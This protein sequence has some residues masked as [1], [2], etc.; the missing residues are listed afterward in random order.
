MGEKL[1]STLDLVMEKFKDKEDDVRLSPAQKEKI[2][3]IKREYEAKI[4]E[5]KIILTGDKDLHK[6]IAFLE[7]EKD[8]KIKSI[9][10]E[11]SKD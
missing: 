4:A 3:E 8:K 7:R 5:K 11:A 10:E 2:A 1:K 6:E 9:Y